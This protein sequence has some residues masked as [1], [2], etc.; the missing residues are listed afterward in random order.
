MLRNSSRKDSEVRSGPESNFSA[1]KTTLIQTHRYIWI[2]QRYMVRYQSWDIFV[3]KLSIFFTRVFLLLIYKCERKLV[4]NLTSSLNSK[5]NFRVKLVKIKKLKIRNHRKYILHFGANESGIKS[6]SKISDMTLESKVEISQILGLT[7]E[8][9]WSRNWI[10]SWFPCIIW[11]KY[12]A[13][14]KKINTPL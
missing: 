1:L 14:L 2:L 11:E 12:R 4:E 5:H 7:T 8:S 13:K 6:R 9:S 10:F 3:F